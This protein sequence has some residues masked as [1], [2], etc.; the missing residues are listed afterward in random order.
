MDLFVMSLKGATMSSASKPH[1]IL[2]QAQRTLDKHGWTR[3]TWFANQAGVCLEGAVGIRGNNPKTRTAP[4]TKACEYIQQAAQQII[5][6][7]GDGARSYDP[8]GAGSTSIPNLNDG[9]LKDKEEAM[10]ILELAEQLAYKDY[11]AEQEKAA[12]GDIDEDDLDDV[13]EIVIDWG[14]FLDHQTS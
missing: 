7:D 11:L 2:A 14:T 12:F 13:E 1:K 10:A 4:R 5:A 8:F 9:L 3:F 6:Q